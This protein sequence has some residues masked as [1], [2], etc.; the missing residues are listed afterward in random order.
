MTE[1]SLAAQAE[2]VARQE[3]ARCLGPTQ[4]AAFRVTVTRQESGMMLE[5]RTQDGQ[6][7]DN[8][9]IEYQANRSVFL[10][11]VRYSVREALSRMGLYGS[12]G[13]DA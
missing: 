3:L 2:S 7:A 5:L 10:D 11:V 1:R 4:A 12:S 8:S 9:A 13:A 6:H